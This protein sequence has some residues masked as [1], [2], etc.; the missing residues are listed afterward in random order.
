MLRIFLTILALTLPIGS[1]ATA[2]SYDWRKV[3]G[4]SVKVQMK[5]DLAYE[6][7]KERSVPIHFTMGVPFSDGALITRTRFPSKEGNLG[8]M[9]FLSP[10]ED[11]LEFVTVSFGTVGGN[12]PDDRLQEVFNVIEGQVYPLLDAPENANILGGRKTEV[13]GRPAVEFISLFDNPAGPVAARIMGVI[14]PNDTDVVFVVQQAMREKLQLGGV[15]ELAET[16]G[17]SM[18]SSLTFQAYR[19]ASGSLIEF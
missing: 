19:D 10:D 13:S 2:Q 8:E 18:V 7:S 11:L 14:A 4:Q 15:S 12:T 16:F 1:V 6:V 9:I 5:I 17:G 3:L